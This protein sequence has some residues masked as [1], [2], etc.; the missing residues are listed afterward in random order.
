MAL[1]VY[2][3]WP[4]VSVQWL[5]VPNSYA[6]VTSDTINENY[7]SN[8]GKDSWKWNEVSH[9]HDSSFCNVYQCKVHVCCC[10]YSC[11]VHRTSWI[12]HTMKQ[13]VDY[14]LQFNTARGILAQLVLKNVLPCSYDYRSS[15]LFDVLLT[16]FWQNSGFCLNITHYTE[17]IWYRGHKNLQV[18][19]PH[20]CKFGIHTLSSRDRAVFLFQCGKTAF[21]EM[22]LFL[23]GK[24]NSSS[25]GTTQ[26]MN[27]N[28]APICYWGPVDSY[29]PCIIG[30]LYIGWR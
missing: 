11:M 28:L 19:V 15:I 23:L 10:I 16:K 18:S 22:E 14:H 17:S 21:L 29:D 8:P 4:W 3:C 6:S 1:W 27:T 7:T 30:L 5:C 25:M 13:K 2:I 26:R 9:G 20:W 24:R 12:I